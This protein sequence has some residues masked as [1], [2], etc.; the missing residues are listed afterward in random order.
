MQ[1]IVF[2]G[3]T[4]T[5]IGAHRTPKPDDLFAKVLRLLPKNNRKMPS[6]LLSQNN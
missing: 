5:T 3:K 1:M 6:E 4:P 2:V